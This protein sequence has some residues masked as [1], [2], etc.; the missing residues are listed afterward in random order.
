MKWSIF[1]IMLLLC[2]PVSGEAQ[3]NKIDT[4]KRKEYK[5]E[6]L[7]SGFIDIM[8]NVQINASARFIRLY[9]GEPQK[10]EIPLSFYVG[11]TNIIFKTKIILH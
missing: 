3:S 4:L 9:I 5:P 8:N 1:A 6:I 11:L 10:F 2:L 7:T